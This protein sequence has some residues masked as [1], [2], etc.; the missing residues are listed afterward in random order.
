MGEEEGGGDGEKMTG[1]RGK[2]IK[3]AYIYVYT[4]YFGCIL[5]ERVMSEEVMSDK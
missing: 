1:A 2:L 4:N 3:S 5:M